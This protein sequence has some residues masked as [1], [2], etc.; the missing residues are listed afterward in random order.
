MKNFSTRVGVGS[1]GYSALL[2]PILLFSTLSFACSSTRLAD[3]VLIQ[4]TWYYINSDG[5]GTVQAAMVFSTYYLVSYCAFAMAEG[6]ILY[7]LN[8]FQ[9]PLQ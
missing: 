5:L 1:V 9:L 8:I 3:V 6:I 4:D 7:T 2:Y